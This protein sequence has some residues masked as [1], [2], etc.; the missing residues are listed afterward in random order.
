[1]SDEFRFDYDRDA[2]LGRGLGDGERLWPALLSDA[3]VEALA[4]HIEQYPA[5]GSEPENPEGLFAQVRECAAEIH[6]ATEYLFVESDPGS[7]LAEAAEQYRA[8]VQEQEGYRNVLKQAEQRGVKDDD[9]VFDDVSSPE[10]E[11]LWEL[12]EYLPEGTPLG[13]LGERLFVDLLGQAVGMCEDGARRLLDLLRLTIVAAPAKPTADFLRRVSRCYLWG[14]DAECVILCRS[15]LD[16]AFRE[17]MS[18][19]MCESGLEPTQRR[20]SLAD[21]IKAA[22]KKKLINYDEKE[23]A[24]SVKERGDKAVHYDPRATQDICGTVVLTLTVLKAI[25]QA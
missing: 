17:R 7:G 24:F 5:R 1:M 15:A 2:I 23:A 3:F 4:Q 19:E 9:D 8:F 25:T 13:Y 22:F 11:A 16:T 18:D 20:F 10:F 12:G 21:W 6:K 14:F